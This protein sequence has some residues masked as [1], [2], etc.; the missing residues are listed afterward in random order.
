MLPGLLAPAIIVALGVVAWSRAWTDYWSV[1]SGLRGLQMAS[2]GAAGTRL[3]DAAAIVGVGLALC[4]AP[5]AVTVPRRLPTW[6]GVTA[7]VA[8]AV[9]VGLMVGRALP[10]GV[11]GAF[12]LALF[13]SLAYTP[14]LG[15]WRLG[16]ERR[17]RAAARL[18]AA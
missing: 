5:L 11:Y 4:L 17:R 15:L 9:C 3:L 2:G 7:V 13:M 1:P 16:R 6:C 18:E 10:A 8:G 12:D 14:A